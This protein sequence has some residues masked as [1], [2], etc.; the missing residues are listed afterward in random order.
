MRSVIGVQYPENARY[1]VDNENMATVGRFNSLAKAKAFT[2]TLKKWYLFDIV[3]HSAIHNDNTKK[4]FDG[5]LDPV[6]YPS[7]YNSYKL[8]LRFRKSSAE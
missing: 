7:M 1:L 2:K 4:S 3:A 6:V 5:F 8:M